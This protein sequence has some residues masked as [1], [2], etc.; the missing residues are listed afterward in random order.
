MWL[1]D[2]THYDRVW[3]MDIK[4]VRRGVV[5]ALAVVCF[6]GGGYLVSGVRTSAPAAPTQV[7]QT[8]VWND[9]QQRRD[10]LQRD[11]QPHGPATPT[12]APTT[13]DNPE[14]SV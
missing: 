10:Q 2:R 5:G 11:M 1:W 14:R 9:L 8:A 4:K 7:D 13:Q 6:A 3:G 12:P